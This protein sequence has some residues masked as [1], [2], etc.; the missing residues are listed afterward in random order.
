MNGMYIPAILAAV[1]LLLAGLWVLVPILYGVPWRPTHADRIRKALK[2]AGLRPDELVYDLGAGDGRV[3][4]LAAREFGAQGVGIEVGFLQVMFAGVMAWFNG[5]SSR[6]RMM[7]G[8]FYRADLHE[9]DVVF[10]YLTSDQAFHLQKQLGAQ[11]KNGARVIT[12]S[13][14]LPGWQPEAF[15]RD[16][17][18]FLYRTPP[19]KGDLASFLNTQE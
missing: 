10:A 13:F 8:N 1:V 15:D 3:I 19:V 9:A 2:L 16:N 6:V 11:L 14:D 4:I 5:V 18:I 7:R 12:I 17:L